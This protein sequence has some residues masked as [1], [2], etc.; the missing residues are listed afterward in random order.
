MTNLVNWNNLL[1]NELKKDYFKKII[2][3]IK[4]RKSNGYKI[5]PDK[6]KIF[7]ALNVTKFSKT[8]IIIIGQDP[9]HKSK[10]AD[11]LAF[12]VNKGVKIPPSLFNIFK[13]LKNNINNFT[14]PNHGH[15][16]SWAKQGVLLL[17]SIL[18]VEENKPL[19]HSKIGWEIFTNK[20]IKMLN[21]Y[22]YGL[23]FLLW[24]NFAKKKIKYINKNKHFI[25]TASHP[26]P[27]SANYGFFGCR[28][29]N[30]ANNI[31]IKKSSKP[32]NWLIY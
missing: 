29:F 17:N 19:S 9:Y 18:T 21:Y 26:S 1:K 10:Q 3:F 7:Y 27:Y 28:H 2:K 8:K 20:I 32:I 22:H 13:E 12:S 23:I 24:G 14:I 16:Y 4:N 5:Y 11:G 15:L 31:L 30:I 25:L 6:D